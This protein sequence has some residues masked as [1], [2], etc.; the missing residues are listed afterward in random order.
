MSRILV[1]SPHRDDE[2]IGCGGTIRAHTER[3][4]D[5][6]VVHVSGESGASPAEAR[7]ACAILGVTDIS[8]LSGPAIQLEATEALLTELVAVFR[9]RRPDIVY[10]PHANDDDPTH[11]VTARA[12]RQA[13]WIAAYPVLAEAGPPTQAHACTVYEYEVWTPLARPSVFVDIT[14]HRER[15]IRALTCYSSQLEISCWVEGALGLNRYRGVTSGHGEYVEAFS[16]SHI[17]HGLST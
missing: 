12:V 13:R 6:A 1:V 14:P 3:G 7:T 17:P 5:V 9:R 4:D 10:V 2:T 8:T 15:K 16:V 11:E